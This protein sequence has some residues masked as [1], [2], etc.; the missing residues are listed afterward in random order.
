MA[1]YAI[2][3]SHGQTETADSAAIDAGALGISHVER[4]PETIGGLVGQI[5]RDRIRQTTRHLERAG[6]AV[7]TSR[8]ERGQS[9][10]WW[11]PAA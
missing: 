10:I 9:F 1:T 4:D 7:S 11:V 8:D 3:H 2:K 5:D 6:F